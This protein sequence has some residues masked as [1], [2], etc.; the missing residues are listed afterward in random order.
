[1]SDEIKNMRQEVKRYKEKMKKAMPRV[2]TDYE[3]L[4]DSAL[5]E[6]VLPAKIKELIAIGIAIAKQCKD[7]IVAHVN[8]ALMAGASQEEIWD[9]CRMAIAMGGGPAV[10][11]SRFTMKAV[12]ES[13][14]IRLP[15]S[16]GDKAE[17]QRT[18]P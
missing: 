6:G 3:N 1:M 4:R 2:M 11:Y 9:V 17:E 12:E 7:Y 5:E 13:D 18:K 10:A 14:T 16:G 15:I 8:N